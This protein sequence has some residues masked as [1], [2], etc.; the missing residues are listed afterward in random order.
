MLNQQNK[1]YDN[2]KE[3]FDT[4]SMKDIRPNSWRVPILW[5]RR[6]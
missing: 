1:I 6:G 4:V 2:I 3:Y 5:T